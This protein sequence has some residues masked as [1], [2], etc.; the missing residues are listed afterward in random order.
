MV[1][2]HRV[3]L[4]DPRGRRLGAQ[5]PRAGGHSDDLGRRPGP[6]VVD[7]GAGISDRGLHA[8]MEELRTPGLSDDVNTPRAVIPGE[9][10]GWVGAP[11][12]IPQILDPP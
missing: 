8:H 10:T 2:A 4:A 6:Q 7:P 9:L 11:D 1:L 5:P 12:R 3:L